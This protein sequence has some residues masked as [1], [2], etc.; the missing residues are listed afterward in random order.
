MLSQVQSLLLRL[1][2]PRKV[3]LLLSLL[4]FALSLA[5]CNNVPACPSGGNDGGCTIG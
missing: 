4:L 2:D 3:A 5:G 1:S